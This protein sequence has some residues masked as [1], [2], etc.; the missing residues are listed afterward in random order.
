MIQTGEVYD[1]VF[2]GRANCYN[3]YVSDPRFDLRVKMK[4]YSGDPDLY[5]N[6]KESNIALNKYKY[7]SLETLESEE[8][9][10]TPAMREDDQNVVGEYF[11]C[12]YGR[13]TSSFK[14]IVRNDDTSSH[15][16]ESGVSESGYLAKNDIINYWY[17][18]DI[19]KSKTNISFQLHAMSGMIT[20]R[21]KKCAVGS[22]FDQSKNDC[23]H[24]LEDLTKPIPDE[25]IF[26]GVGAEII[27]HDPTGCTDT[28]LIN[29][30]REAPPVC[31]YNIGV[32][33]NAENIKS[34]YGVTIRHQEGQHFL[35]TE[36]RMIEGSIVQKQYN[37]YKISIQDPDITSI[38]IQLLAIHGDPDMFMSRSNEYPS[39]TVNEKKATICGKFP[40]TITYDVKNQQ[41]RLDSDSLVG[42]Y[43]IAV[44]GFVESTY[45]LYYETTRSHQDESGNNQTVKLPVKLSQSKSVKGFMRDSTGY[46]IYKF[47]VNNVTSNEEIIIRLTPQNGRFRFFVKFGSEASPINYDKVGDVTTHYAV[48]FDPSVNSTYSRG[49][50]YILVI[51]IQTSDLDVSGM[52]LTYLISYYIG[53]HHIT[54]LNDQPTFGHTKEDHVNYYSYAFSADADQIKIGLTKVSGDVE[55]IISFN[56]DITLPDKDDVNA[57]NGVILTTSDNVFKKELV[58]AYCRARTGTY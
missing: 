50:Y 40:D 44:Y 22:D 3:Y 47:T 20:L 2:K 7:N 56:Q 39:E 42:N 23:T 35:L 29:Y 38:T 5:I 45:H 8:L 11:I 54:L 58:A 18:E 4:V 48:V 17:R 1:N 49:D 14:L 41:D 19:L 10:I 37:Y 51:P 24:N 25:K 36:G 55:M 27:E 43:Y 46:S 30:F 53:S 12:V 32:V 26:Y 6:P 9:V 52:S 34:H 15:M 31:F 57:T 16:L 33:G 28:S 13:F 21:Y